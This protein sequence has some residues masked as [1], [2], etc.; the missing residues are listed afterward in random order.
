MAS[1]IDKWLRNGPERLLRKAG[2]R[3]AY[4]VLDLGCGEGRYAIPAARIVGSAGR[5][6]AVDKEKQHLREIKRRAGKEGLTNI[7]AIHVPRYGRVPLRAGTI[8]VVVLYDVLH[9]GYFPQRSQRDDLLNRIHRLLK[10][11]GI[12]SCHLTHLREYGWTF[13]ETL[14]EIKSAG[15]RLRGQTR[16]RLVHADKLVRERIFQFRKSAISVKGKRKC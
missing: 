9:G 10:P 2:I 14:A 12:L 8:D 15:F 6:F 1:E 5:I 4:R 13:K 7:D 16:P 11:G 3:R